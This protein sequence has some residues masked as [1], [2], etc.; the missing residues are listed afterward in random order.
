MG[1]K[2]SKTELDDQKTERSQ[3]FL[4]AAGTMRIWL[5]ERV[6][7]RHGEDGWRVWE[8]GLVLGRMAVAHPEWFAG[9]TV[10]ELG[11]GVGIGAISILRFTD[12]TSVMLTDYNVGVLDNAQLNVVLNLPATGLD[13]ARFQQLDWREYASFNE[14]FDVII[15]SDIVYDGAPFEELA[16]LIKQA[17]RP[18]GA[19]YIIIPS[20]RF[21]KEDFLKAMAAEPTSLIPEVLP[22]PAE[23]YSYPAGSDVSRSATLYPGLQSLS[24]SVYI[25]RKG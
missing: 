24:F 3:F 15:G 4:D 13:R 12:S 11:T 17:L 10:L 25:F 7:F 6:I 20:Q 19:A 1:G 2:E 23:S 22:L 8:A 16:A 21:R 5:N 9:K 14:T 18:G